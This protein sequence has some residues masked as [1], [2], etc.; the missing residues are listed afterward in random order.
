MNFS[1]KPHPLIA[2][3]VPGFMV[4]LIVS[5]S[6]SDWNYTCL[7]NKVISNETTGARGVLIILTLA[8]VAFVIGEFLDSFRDAVVERCFDR[9]KPIEWDFF[10]KGD[11]DKLKNLMDNY[12]TYYV[13]NSNLALGIIVS[14]TSIILLGLMRWKELPSCRWTIIGLCVLLIF[15][16]WDAMVLRREIKK[17]T[18]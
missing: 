10:F 18:N 16:I 15:F 11:K 9:W 2:H 13:L 14:M 17:H 12:F 6:I 3:W 5:F 4:I 1:L 7:F 8:V